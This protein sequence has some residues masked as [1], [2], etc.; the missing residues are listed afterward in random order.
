MA[1][2]ELEE[3]VSVAK[4]CNVAHQIAHASL[5]KASEEAAIAQTKAREVARVAA[6]AESRA[7]EAANVVR[8]KHLIVGALRI[9]TFMYP[10]A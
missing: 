8:Q 4:D 7:I 10:F 6:E 9:G 5:Q 1:F 2:Q 3:A